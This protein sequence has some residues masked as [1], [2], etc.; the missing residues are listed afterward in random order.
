MIYSEVIIVGGGPAG[1]TCAWQLKQHGLDCLI[2]DKQ[3]FPRTKLCAGWIQLQVIDDLRINVN[4]YPHSLVKFDKF[5]VHL[6]SRELKLKVRQYA[7]RRYEFDHWLLQRSGARIFRHEARNIKK[8]N[9]LYIIDNLYQGKYLVGAGGSSCPV[10]N[11]F[12]RQIYPRAKDLSVVALEEEFPYEYKD[13]NCHLWFL[14]NKLPG[15]SWYVPKSNGYLNIGIGGF[16]EKL[17]VQNEDIK[18]YWQLFIKE[19]DRLALVR[20]YPFKARGYMYYVRDN[21]EQVQID[22]AFIIG[23]AAGLATRDMGEGIGPAVKSGLL[24]AEAILKRKTLSL[25]TIKKYSFPRWK[26]SFKLLIRH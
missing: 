19:L 16:A 9:D 5:H 20:N 2:L 17:K 7:I 25:R 6:H 8:E 15:Y 21:Q 4:E 14:Q 22:N 11:T 18:N 23:D 12:F 13:E 24:A 1:S 10:Y 3:E 26:I